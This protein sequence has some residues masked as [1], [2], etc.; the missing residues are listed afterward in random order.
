MSDKDTPMRQHRAS[1]NRIARCHPVPL[2]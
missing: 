1:N 2:P